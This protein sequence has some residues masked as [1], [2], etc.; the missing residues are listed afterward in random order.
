MATK[1]LN[2]DHTAAIIEVINKSPFYELLSIKITALE[3]GYCRGELL[4]EEKHNSPLGRM[5]GG[6]YASAID[7]VAWWSAYGS[8]SEESGMTSIDLHVDNVSAVQNGNLS[9]EGRVLKAGKTLC[10]AEGTVKDEDGKLL[11]FGTSKLLVANNLQTIKQAL[12]MAGHGSLPP[13]YS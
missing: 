12:E 4:L 7:T 6:V 10:F 13:K 3:V 5:H 9:V 11:A 1:Q 8:V 2:P